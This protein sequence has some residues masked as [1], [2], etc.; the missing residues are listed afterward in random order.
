MPKFTVEHKSPQ[1]PIDTFEKVKTFMT[2]GD[3]FKKYDPS[4]QCTFDEP[5]MTCHIK[6][7]QF[8]AEMKVAAQAQGSQV[9]ISIDLP[10]LL[11]PFKSKIQDSLSRMLT[12]H[13]S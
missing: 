3:E 6:G 12:K 2:K 7:S 13:L 11:T 1:S 4:I 5:Q 10:F 8:K 9:T